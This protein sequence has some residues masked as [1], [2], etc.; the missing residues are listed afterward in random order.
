MSRLTVYSRWSFEIGMEL[1]GHRRPQTIDDAQNRNDKTAWIDSR[2][3]RARYGRRR[4]G[5][6]QA[7]LSWYSSFLFGRRLSPRGATDGGLRTARRRTGGPISSPV[8]VATVGIRNRRSVIRRDALERSESRN[9][10]RATWRVNCA[11]VGRSYRQMQNLKSR[12]P[13]GPAS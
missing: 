8:P 13:A 12:E 2:R 11:A 9:R 1:F 5:R 7:S 4:Y 10:P 3:T 6:R